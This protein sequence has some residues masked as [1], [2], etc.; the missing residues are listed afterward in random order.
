MRNF[1]RMSRRDLGGRGAVVTWS[2]AALVAAAVC[3]AQTVGAVDG[4]PPGR[5][6]RV[7][8]LVGDVS[9]QAQGSDSWSQPTVN[10][11]ITT[12]DRLFAPAGA[13]AELDLGASAIRFGDAADVTVTN[14]TDHFAQLGLAGGA[15]R[16]SI[17][18]WVP[19]DSIEVDTPNGALLPL[20][21]GSYRVSVDPTGGITT[22][23]VE[24]GS[25]EIS[26]PGLDRT[27]RG[28]TFQLT[29]TNPIV[30]SV[31]SSPP[32]DG[33]EQWAASR[34]Q[35]F[36]ANAPSV[37]YVGNYVPGWE[38]LDQYGAWS[39]DASYGPVWY[40]TSVAA[41]WVPYRDGH[42]AW[43][44][45]WG[46]SW[47]DDAAWGFAPS[48][49]G[50]WAQ[51]S[52]GWGWVPG[53]VV[54]RPVYAPAFVVFVDGASF[55]QPQYPGMQAWF[56]LAPREPFFPWYHHSD[57]YLRQ[58]NAANLR[59][60]DVNTIIQVR[61]VNAYQWRNRA[62]AMTVVREET[63][64]NGYPVQRDVIRVRP[65]QVVGARIEAHPAVGPEAR[66]ISGGLPARR[67][68][69]IAR[70]L[71]VHPVPSS[72]KPLIANETP[73]PARPRMA[74]PASP[75]YQRPT[76]ATPTRAVP[77][78]SHAVASRDTSG[79]D[80]T[81]DHAEHAAGDRIA[82]GCASSRD[83]SASGASARATAD[84]GCSGRSRGEP[85]A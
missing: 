27:V 55:R 18:R 26:G 46:W 31:L 59:G 10:Y 81:A 67:P 71:M 72:P 16:L 73:Q 29:G 20:T 64:R 65:E 52:R 40:P 83:G 2:V 43:V 37:Q 78:G 12:G 70:P 84:R 9:F 13:R 61:D 49:Y 80:S 75:V 74:A 66:L 56:P 76:P 14:L 85:A 79:A 42:W 19:S 35:R 38:D 82:A 69:T 22:V 44:E 45:P 17:Y 5:V 28:G 51:F 24:S 48:H 50:R 7:S 77:G 8:A 62:Q 53:P 6:A 54:Q 60:V 34:D 58:I 15:T 47:V 36:E 3:G 1:V 57:T 11:T 30:F 63:L 21:A 41:D 25:L 23:T 39:T 4:D 33:F 68:P 32:R